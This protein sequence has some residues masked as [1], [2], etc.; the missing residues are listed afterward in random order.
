MIN[1]PIINRL[2]GALIAI[3]GP[4]IAIIGVLIAII[5]AFNHYLLLLGH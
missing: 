4:L 1:D 2:I 5:G 3:I